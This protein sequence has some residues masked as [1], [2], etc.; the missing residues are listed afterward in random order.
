MA[1]LSCFNKNG[2]LK[3]IQTK[4]YNG[5]LPIRFPASAEYDTAKVLLWSD[6]SEMRPLCTSE[7]L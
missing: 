6:L 2:E 5:E 7:S 4:I 3:E 1:L